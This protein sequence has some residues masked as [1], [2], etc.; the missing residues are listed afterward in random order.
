MHGAG[1]ANGDQRVDLKVNIS[2]NN[3]ADFLTKS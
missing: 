2:G 1:S 3:F